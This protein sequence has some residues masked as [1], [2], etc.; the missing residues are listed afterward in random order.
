MSTVI[1]EIQAKSIL[2]R[3]GIPGADYC[4]NAY[5]G[6]AHARVYCNATF[7][8]KYTG[9]TEPWGKCV[10][11]KMNAPESEACPRDKDIIGC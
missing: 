8:K 7:M 2:S 9:H 3:S 11:I 1:R 4:F 10:D 6:C 5:A